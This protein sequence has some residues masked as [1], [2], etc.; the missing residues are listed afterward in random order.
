MFDLSPKD[1]EKFEWFKGEGERGNKGI[2]G[3]EHSVYR[4]SVGGLCTHA[5][6]V[7]HARDLEKAKLVA[8]EE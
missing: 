7:W 4:G 8:G 6:R 2:P 3:R 1:L 5:G